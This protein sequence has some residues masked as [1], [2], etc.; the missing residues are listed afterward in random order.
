MMGLSK[1]IFILILLISINASA[2]LYEGKVIDVVDKLPLEKATIFIENQQK[3]IDCD[4]KGVF[5]IEYDGKSTL[6]VSV[7]HIGYGTR[8]HIEL[9]IEE[10]TVIIL[11]PAA[12]N[13]DNV[14]VTANRYSREAYKVTQPITSVSSDQIEAGGHTIVADVIRDFPGIDM[15]DAG[16]FRAR[17]VIRG[18]YGT[19]ILVLVDGERL[20]DQRDVSAFAGVTMSLVDVNEIERVEVVNGPSSV[21]YGSDA[22]GG[23]INIITRSVNFTDRFTPNA[24]Y[25]GSFSINE[26]HHSHRLDIGLSCR[27]LTGSVGILYREALKDYQ[28]PKGWN[29][30]NRYYPFRSDYYENLNK[31]QNT[32]Y[33]PTRLAN[34]R[35]K[36][37]NFDGKL[38]YKLSEKYKLDLDMGFF[39][40]D[41]VGYP[42]VPND[43]TPLL[44]FY[45]NHDRDNFALTFT[46]KDIS[47]RM[48]KLTGRLYYEK[49][50][51]EFLT[52]FLGSGYVVLNPDPF[53]SM[54]LISVLNYTEV[55]KYGFNFQELYGIGEQTHLTF[56]FDILHEKIDG[57]VTTIIDFTGLGP[58]PFTDTTVGASVPKSD[59]TSLGVYASGETSFEDMLVTL[60]VRFDNY[61]IKTKETKG[62]TDSDDNPLPADDE[63]YNSF[64]GSFGITYPLTEEVNLV[65]NVGTAFRVP[66]TVERF[67]YGSASGRETRPNPDIKPEKSISID[68]GVKAIH[69]EF[70]YSL[71]GFYS[72]YT[73]FAQFQNFAFETIHG[74]TTPLWRYEN[75]EDV[76][77]Y[78]FEGIIEVNPSDGIYSRL[79]LSYQHGQNESAETPIF[80]SPLK[81]SVTM[82]YRNQK[83]KWY[84][85]FIIKMVDHQDRVPDVTY[86]DDI[87]TRGYWLL[88]AVFG[89]QVNEHVKFSLAARNILDEVYSEP[90]NAR[91]PDNPIPE[92]GRNL[93]ISITANL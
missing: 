79:N 24:S 10:P 50:S 11:A 54:D 3:F 40:A 66:N 41:D 25:R 15:N 33:D 61:W 26:E 13:L 5:Q 57:D 59:W 81:T 27:K 29:R 53:S 32:D 34:S 46:G 91:N 55:T 60:G 6:K 51:K 19:R 69:K 90:F 28:P 39:R 30:E 43:S 62:Y 85:E 21:L 88:N 71:M 67:F 4:E 64:N 73:D 36:V 45:P 65:A 87:P 89:I 63:T 74:A 93:T 52:D 92:P 38:A 70:N 23:V 8:K 72:D 68:Y 80:V 86:L 47:R 9:N 20:N 22:M 2:A 84:G 31:D 77:I 7:S 78:G 42:G 83:Q 75:I 17:P 14:V 49:I 76:V 48:A 82:G 58:F 16:P 56:G 37:Q 44:F 12:S 18:L 35:A 1:K